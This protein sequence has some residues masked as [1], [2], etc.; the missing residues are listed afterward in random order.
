MPIIELLGKAF[1]RPEVGTLRACF[2]IIVIFIVLVLLILKSFISIRGSAFGL[3]KSY[4]SP[5]RL[6]ISIDHF[7]IARA[8]QSFAILKQSHT[9]T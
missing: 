4:F 7:C 2:S 3:C 6:L 5:A 1:W 8:V 9:R